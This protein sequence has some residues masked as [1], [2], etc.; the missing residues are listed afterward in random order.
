MDSGDKKG[1]TCKYAL[2]FKLPS[3]SMAAFLILG[4]CS[5]PAML[6]KKVERPHL[7]LQCN[8][9]HKAPDELLLRVKKGAGKGGDQGEARA[10]KSDLNGLCL[11]CHRAGNNDHSIAKVPKINNSNL[12]LD[13]DGRITCATTCHDVHT[14]NSVNTAVIKG[15][16]R[17]PPEDLCFSCHDI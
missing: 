2:F 14:K 9:C 5:L 12:P 11:D 8:A 13:S 7:K 17:I 3:L 15:L 10:M 4:G 6:K 1:M 16:L